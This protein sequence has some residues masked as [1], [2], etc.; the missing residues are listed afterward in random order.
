M[1]AWRRWFPPRVQTTDP[2]GYSPTWGSISLQNT[3][4]VVHPLAL[5]GYD[6]P[7]FHKLKLC[8][9][10]ARDFYQGYMTTGPGSCLSKKTSYMFNSGTSLA[11]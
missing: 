6:T 7:G 8:F 5:P 3:H 1:P 4:W 11:L 2:E 10:L 9:D